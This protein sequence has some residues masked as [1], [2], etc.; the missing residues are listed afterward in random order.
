MRERHRLDARTF[1][2]LGI[3]ALTITTLHY[4]SRYPFRRHQ[5]TSSYQYP[6]VYLKLQSWH[7][8]RQH[9]NPIPLS[10]LCV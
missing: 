5:V 8:V 10:R 1:E 2:L 3:R 6:I 4:T 7:R 9:D